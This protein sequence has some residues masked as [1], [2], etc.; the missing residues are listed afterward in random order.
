[1]TKIRIVIADDHP[2][3]SRGLCLALSS[4]AGM[5]VVGEARD[6]E[7]AIQQIR[8][9][10]PD[11]AILDVDMPRKD[12]LQ[13]VRAIAEENLL[14]AAIFLTMHKNQSLFEAA[15]DLGVRGYVL[16]DSA[17]SEAAECVKAVAAGHNF[18]SPALA[19]YLFTQ[20][21]RR[22]SLIVDQPGLNDLTPAERRVL[23]LIADC[24][25][26][27]EIAE[28]L[29]LSIR[30]IEHHRAHIC[31]KLNLHGRETLLRFALSNRDDLA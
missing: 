30:T 20:R 2:I 24:K 18:V 28:E 9:C 19:T 23:R 29:C 7:S 13:V 5:E 1:M 26:N 25:S 21:S 4:D 22:K 3:F 11:V 6:G 15:L 14:A 10:K 27:A 16:K 17:L 12:G 8:A 31:A